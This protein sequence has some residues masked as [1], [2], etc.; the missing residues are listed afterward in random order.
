MLEQHSNRRRETRIAQHY[1]VLIR[2]MDAHGNKVKAYGMT[3]NISSG[4][5]LLKPS[6]LLPVESSIFAFIYL[7]NNVRLAALGEIL[8]SSPQE[9]LPQGIAVHFRKTRLLPPS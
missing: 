3:E 6:R 2:G 5:M 7:P 8:R 4:G 1:T 9:P